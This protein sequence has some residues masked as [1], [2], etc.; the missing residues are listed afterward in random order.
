MPENPTLVIVDV[1]KAFDDPRGDRG[2]TPTRKGNVAR[3]LAA[4]R[5]ADAPIVH[6]RHRETDPEWHFF[7]EGDPWIRVQAGSDAAGG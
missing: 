3:L 7:N 4:W 5:A 6:V 2:T 1:Q